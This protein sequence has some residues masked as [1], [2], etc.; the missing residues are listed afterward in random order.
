MIDL[1]AS[2]KD[3]CTP[4]MA[5]LS[6]EGPMVEGTTMGCYDDARAALDL[7]SLFSKDLSDRGHGASRGGPGQRAGKPK[8][9]LR[10]LLTESP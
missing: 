5:M 7:T 2:A 3:G 6:A 9:D 8:T 4:K 10:V 1:N